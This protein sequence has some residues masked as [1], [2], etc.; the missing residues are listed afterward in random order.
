MAEKQ[1]DIPPGFKH[2]WYLATVEVDL[3]PKWPQEVL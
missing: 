2:L 3:H 1:I